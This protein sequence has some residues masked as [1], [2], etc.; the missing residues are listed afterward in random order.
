MEDIIKTETEIRGELKYT[1]HWVDR[2]IRPGDPTVN[3]L[4]TMSVEG[5]SKTTEVIKYV[6]KSTQEKS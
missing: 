4:G 5:D 2:P 1:T 6:Y 3:A